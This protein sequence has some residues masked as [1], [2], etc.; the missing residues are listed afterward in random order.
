MASLTGR[1]LYFCGKTPEVHQLAHLLLEQ[2]ERHLHPEDLEAAS[3]GPEQAPRASRMMKMMLVSGPQVPK[4]L[5]PKPVVVSTETM[6]K[7]LMRRASMK[8]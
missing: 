3:G 2:G 8:P 6:L 4:S 7:Q 1:P 5:S